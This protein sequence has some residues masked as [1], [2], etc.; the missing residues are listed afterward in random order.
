MR[1][2]LVSRGK[3]EL[4]KAQFSKNRGRAEL[5]DLLVELHAQAEA[6]LERARELDGRG[7]GADREAEQ[8]YR[9]AAEDLPEASLALAELL[10]RTGRTAEAKVWYRD[11]KE[12]GLERPG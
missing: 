10:E 2:A 6:L 1:G 5:L 7:A 3:K 12:D 9:R 8:L 4:V 11:A